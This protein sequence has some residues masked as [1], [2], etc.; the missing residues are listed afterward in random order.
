MQEPAAIA[1]PP[2]RLRTFAA[3]GVRDFRV[4]WA[5][6]WA[7][8]IPFFMANVV[9]GVVAFHLAHVNRAVGTVVFAQGV[10]MAVL[11][12]IGGAGADRWPKRRVLA[13]SQSAAAA[14]FGVFALLLAFDRL[15]IA[16]LSGGAFVLGISIS[17]LGPARQAFAAELVGPELRGNAVA[18][19][20]VPL[21]GSQVLGPAIAGLMLASPFGATGAY[22]LMGALYATSALSLLALPHSIAR[23]NAAETHVLEDLLIGLRYVVSHRRLR[24]LVGFFVCVIMMGFSYITVL[25]GLVEHALG[26]SA[27]A[28]PP[29]FFTSALGGLLV[30]LVTARLAGSSR[31][32][33]VFVGMPFVLAAGLLG[34]YLAPSYPLAIAAMFLVGIGF[35]GFQT[36]NAAVI[37]QVTEPA[38]FGRVFSLSM[39]AFAGVSLMSLPVGILADAIGERATLATLAGVVLAFALLVGMRLLRT[40]GG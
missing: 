7:S 26:R 34:L 9:N 24:L 3:F 37:V 27:D 35:G 36:L 6:T 13:L 11:A 12:P 23:A 29:L 2:E 40:S 19:N 30:T 33:P 4:L 16:A 10:A 38:Y 18:L 22:A 32:L 39:L 20:Q 1:V 21:T 15:S 8:Y 5:G 17:F 31:A 14:V 28:V 25:P